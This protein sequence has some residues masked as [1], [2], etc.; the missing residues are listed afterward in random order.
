M[1]L[2]DRAVQISVEVADG[3]ADRTDEATRLL[4]GELVRAIGM[5]V[6]PE[7]A[8]VP[9][10]AKS[11]GAVVI[12]SLVAGGVLSPMTVRELVRL[13][14]AFVQRG[15]ARRV[16]LEQDGDKLTLEAVPANTQKAL[17]DAWIERRLRSDGEPEDL[18]QPSFDREDKEG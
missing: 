18:G 10:S 12:G 15:A 8:A 13:A 5:D 14:A 16:V 11:A 1:N 2:G 6:R 7:E 17:A 9:R 4:S 3:E